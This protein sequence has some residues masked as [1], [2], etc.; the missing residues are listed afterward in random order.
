MI[1][2]VCQTKLQSEFDRDLA[3]TDWDFCYRSSGHLQN[4]I[5]NFDFVYSFLENKEDLK[6]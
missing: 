2:P 3:T 5:Q 6:E 4:K 1:S